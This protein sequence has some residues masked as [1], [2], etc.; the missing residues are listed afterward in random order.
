MV[1]GLIQ[2][3]AC[4]CCFSSGL[5]RQ[6]KAMHIRPIGISKWSMCLSPCE[7]G[8]LLVFLVESSHIRPQ[9]S[10]AIHQH[11]YNSD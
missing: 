7:C 2:P 6:S 9:G 1:V 8:W 10:W 11:P 3:R 5:R 4:L